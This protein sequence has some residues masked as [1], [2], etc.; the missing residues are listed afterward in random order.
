MSRGASLHSSL[1]LSDSWRRWVVQSPGLVWACLC[2]YPRVYD[3]AAFLTLRCAVSSKQQ[4]VISEWR[5]L[6]RVSETFVTENQWKVLHHQHSDEETPFNPGKL[7]RYVSF[8]IHHC[9]TQEALRNGREM[10]GLELY[11]TLNVQQVLGHNNS[12]LLHRDISYLHCSL[13]CK[14]SQEFFCVANIPLNG[15]L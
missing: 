11:C 9:A 2:V 14:Q 13:S 12:L 7:R 5:S 6:I 8:P 10:F 3:E 15:E 1:S 4:L